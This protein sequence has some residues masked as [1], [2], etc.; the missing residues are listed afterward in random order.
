M[1]LRTS[2]R[3]GWAPNMLLLLSLLLT[4]SH[5]LQNYTYKGE[6]QPKNLPDN[7][8]METQCYRLPYGTVGIVNDGVTYWTLSVLSLGRQPLLPW[9]KLAFPYLTFVVAFLHI[10]PSLTITAMN[11]NRCSGTRWHMLV[12]ALGQA[13]RSLLAGAIAI[14]SGISVIARTREWTYGYQRWNIGLITCYFG[15]TGL[16][17]A[18]WVE[19]VTDHFQIREIGAPLHTFLWVLVGATSLYVL[20]VLVWWYRRSMRYIDSAQNLR[21]DAAV[22]PGQEEPWRE[23]LVGREGTPAARAYERQMKELDSIVRQAND[24]AREAISRAAPPEPDPTR[25]AL[26]LLVPFGLAFVVVT[27]LALGTFYGD[28]VLAII[29]GRQSGLP[30]PG[31][32]ASFWVCSEQSTIR[33][34][35]AP[36]PSYLSTYLS[37]R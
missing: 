21:R 13:L 1:G 36:S 8:A 23:H 26:I 34:L 18:G 19:L 12:L 7:M 20:C 2:T 3:G 10:V 30:Q 16:V 5:A 14:N 24:M 35:P 33:P 28:L 25:K 29:K 11:V 9:N 37:C 32:A 6:P 4:Q 17:T 15:A 31:Y 22:A 27:A